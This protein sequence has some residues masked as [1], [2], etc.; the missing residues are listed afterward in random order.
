RVAFVHSRR[1]L[2]RETLDWATGRDALLTQGTGRVA[3]VGG[4]LTSSGPCF[5][6][7]SSCLGRRS[8]KGA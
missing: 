5:A 1:S 3:A 6:W 8:L 7:D 2:N 4:S